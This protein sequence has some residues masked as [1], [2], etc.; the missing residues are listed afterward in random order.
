MKK[1]SGHK[2]CLS[3]LSTTSVQNILCSNKYLASYTHKMGV[4]MH[5]NLHVKYRFMLPNLNQNWNVLA[6][7][8]KTP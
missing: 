8:S 2:M 4:E 3:F 5:V 7:S 1:Y 6:T